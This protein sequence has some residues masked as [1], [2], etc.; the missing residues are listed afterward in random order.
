MASASVSEVNP[1]HCPVEYIL[2]L[3]SNLAYEAPVVR[4]VIEEANWVKFQ[5]IIN[6]ELVLG[7]LTSE[8]DIDSCIEHLTQVIN[9]A[10]TE[11]IPVRIGMRKY[12]NIRAQRLNLLKKTRISYGAL[13]SKN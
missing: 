12:T 11:S 6:D 10:M 9:H 4:Y 3:N 2:E 5:E 7:P 8:D 13:I 1:D